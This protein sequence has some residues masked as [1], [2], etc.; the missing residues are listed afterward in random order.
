M[1]SKIKA[2]VKVVADIV[3]G[4]TE[5]QK[6]ELVAGFWPKEHDNQG[7]VL[8]YTGIIESEHIES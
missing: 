6:L 4:W 5:E 1:S 2:S 7:Q 8:F 3:D